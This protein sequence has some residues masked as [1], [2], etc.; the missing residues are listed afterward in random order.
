[1]TWLSFSPRQHLHK[2]EASFNKG[3]D[4]SNALDMA[5]SIHTLSLAT[6]DENQLRQTSADAEGNSA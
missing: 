1:M 2:S 6:T 3:R 5:R 4:Y